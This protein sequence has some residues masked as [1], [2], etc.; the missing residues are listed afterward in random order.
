MRTEI[1]CIDPGNNYSGMVHF[2]VD[3]TQ[4]YGIE[5][6]SFNGKMCNEELLDY[7]LKLKNQCWVPI[8]VMRPCGLPVSGE[9]FET[10]IFVG[11]Y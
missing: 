10:M 9:S 5:I 8:E 11:R 3:K 7:V 1:C 6:L 4:L 2:A